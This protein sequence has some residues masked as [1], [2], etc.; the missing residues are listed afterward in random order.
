MASRVDAL[1]VSEGVK[2]ADGYFAHTIKGDQND[3]V[4]LMNKATGQ[5]GLSLASAYKN[6]SYVRSAVRHRA[7]AVASIPFTIRRLGAKPETAPIFDSDVGTV[8]KGLEWLAKLQHLNFLVESALTLEGKAAIKKWPEGERR[9]IET[10]MWCAPN[11]VTPK[12]DKRGGLEYFKHDVNG[13]EVKVAIEDMIFIAPIDVYDETYGTTSDGNSIKKN[14]QILDSLYT[15]LGKS[16]K[17]DLLKHVLLLVPKG[18]KKSERSLIKQWMKKNA[19][20]AR[21][22]ERFSV[23]EAD[24]INPIVIGNGLEDL[25]DTDIEKEQRMAIATGLRV[26]LAL[27]TNEVSNKATSIQAKRDLMIGVAIPEMKTIAAEYNAQLFHELGLHFQ[28]EYER[29]EDL[30]SSEIEQSLGVTQLVEKGVWTPN[31]GRAI[32]GKEPK[33]GGDELREPK[34]APM[35]DV[36]KS[37]DFDAVRE[38]RNWQQKVRSHGRGVKFETNYLPS[39]VSSVIAKRLEDD[40]PIGACFLP[41]WT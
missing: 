41:P 24:T 3:L 4:A 14:A 16:L 36:T 34:S 13:H 15:F 33:D 23:V 26:N 20:G 5:G 6:V 22:S 30:Q 38:L 37:L 1:H 35:P 9:K 39:R 25:H 32:S 2:I 7:G 21:A 8:P 28:P 17:A 18:T 19:A 12:F 27:L 29:I 40:E 31:E 11:R 10:L